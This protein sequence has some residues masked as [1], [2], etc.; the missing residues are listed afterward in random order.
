MKMLKFVKMMW[1]AGILGSVLIGCV[2]SEDPVFQVSDMKTYMIQ[3]NTAAGDK[4][5]GVYMAFAASY[6]TVQKIDLKKND[7][8][9]SVDWRKV[10]EN[11]YELENIN[12]SP[13]ANCN[14]TYALFLTD[15]KGQSDSRAVTFN[16]SKTLGELKLVEPLRYENGIVAAKWENVENVD[17][18]ALL[19]GVGVKE[20]GVT[21]FYRVDAAYYKWQSILENSGRI[22][23][24]V[25]NLGATLS[26][27]IE[28]VV[29]V[30]AISESS[31]ILEGDY[32]KIVLGK[33]GVTPITTP[34]LGLQ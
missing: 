5:F 10:R 19:V 29:A 12:L 2:K 30:A 31:L 11:V 17:R 16:E 27:E 26:Q 8:S 21:K 7:L 18:Y 23:L 32:Y 13:L 24:S 25:S 33:D 28:L 4:Q 34:V 3:K 15:E 1:L 6:G 20:E 22:E 14:G 9:D